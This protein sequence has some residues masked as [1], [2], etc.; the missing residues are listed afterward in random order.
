MVDES[1]VIKVHAALAKALRDNGVDKLF[2]LMGDANLYMI[3]SFVHAQ[4]GD[5]ISAAHEA[6]GASW[7]WATP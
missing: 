7:R 2:G 1:P 3:D 4:D 6:G 5:F